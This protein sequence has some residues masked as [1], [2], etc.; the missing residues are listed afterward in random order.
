MA[1]VQKRWK[2]LSADN[3]GDYYDCITVSDKSF[4]LFI[5]KYYAALHSRLKHWKSATTMEDD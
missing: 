3:H 5:I 4:A 1:A 2:P